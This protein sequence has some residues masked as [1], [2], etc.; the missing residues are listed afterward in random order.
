[1][2]YRRHQRVQAL[3]NLDQVSPNHVRRIAELYA[4]HASKSRQ[5][6]HV[7]NKFGISSCPPALCR[8][9]E[10]VEGVSEIDHG[11][12]VPVLRAICVVR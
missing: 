6:A 8:R 2:L 10:T 4:M 5:L 1:M 3:V 7:E 11:N 9:S 12:L